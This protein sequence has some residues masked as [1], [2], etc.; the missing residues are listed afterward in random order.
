M[1]LAQFLF[2]GRK[3]LITIERNEEI[4]YS[5]DKHI[6]LIQCDKRESGGSEVVLVEP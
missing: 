5:L 3:G 6:I 4:A 2:T 1:T